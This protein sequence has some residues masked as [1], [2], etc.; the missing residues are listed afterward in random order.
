M[1]AMNAD[2][3]VKPAMKTTVTELPESRV[4]LEA[5]VPP[6]VVERE[7]ARAAR[8]FG[9]E[10]RIPGFRKG[11]VPP[12]VVI[13]R[14]GRE[15]V[16]D[17]AV[18]DS[19]GR[20]YADAI[21][22]AR[23]A[24]VGDPDLTLP[25]SLPG[26]GEPYTFTVEIGVRPEAKLGTYKGVEVGRREPEATD[27]QIDAEL[28][29]MQERAARLETAEREAKEGDFVVMDFV[30]SIDGEEFEGGAG[31]DQMI[32]LGS[33]RLIPGFEDQ[34]VGHKAGDEVTVEVTF[35][36]EYGATQLAGKEAQFAVTVKEIKEKV[37]PELDD[38]FA[39]DQAGFDNLQ[40]LRDDIAAKLKEA[41]E[42]AVEQAYREAVIDAVVAEAKID[43]PESLVQARARELWERMVHSLGHQR[44]SKDMYLQ[45]AGKTEDEIISEALPE[46]ETA[47]KRE[48]VLAAVNAAEDI[49]PS[50]GDIL[51]ALQASAARE[52][53]KPEKLRDQLQSAGRLDELKEDL[54]SRRAAD[55]LVEEAKPI[56]VEQAQARNK[57]WTPEKEAS[58]EGTP[59][60]WTPGS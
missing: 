9:R 54:A 19:I 59:E 58:A 1:L 11:K 49:E 7:V 31:R 20:W 41:D 37:L 17:E 14:V 4:R 38:D 2:A 32:E 57:L 52:N 27:E 55:L 6:E 33:G 3:I 39:V 34:L 8:Q 35:P 15:A 43:V 50:D 53:V 48:A 40:E 12:P 60:L 29:Q 21:G 25:D 36:E 18:R 22:E 23:I 47:L 44:I 56:S 42:R 16:L 5:E 30:G 45:M 13:R 26:E 24:P 10:M 51:D 46:A 28:A